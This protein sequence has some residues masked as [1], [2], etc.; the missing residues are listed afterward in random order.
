MTNNNNNNNTFPT[1]L[2]YIYLPQ[3]AM[4]AAKKEKQ[5][6]KKREELEMT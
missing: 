3:D 1:E 6:I 5:P 2:I 4:Q